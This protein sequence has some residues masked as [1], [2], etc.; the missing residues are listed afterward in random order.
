MTGGPFSHLQFSQIRGRQPLDDTTEPRIICS[1]LLP[2]PA[3]LPDDAF[4]A[5]SAGVLEHDRTGIVDK[6]AQLQARLGIA[7]QAR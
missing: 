5:K 7:Q 1:N 2:L 4:Q 3:S 6:F